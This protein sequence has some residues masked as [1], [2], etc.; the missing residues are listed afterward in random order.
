MSF[1]KVITELEIFISNIDQ[2]SVSLPVDTQLVLSVHHS[3]IFWSLAAA[4]IITGK[5]Q[6]VAFQRIHNALES[7]AKLLGESALRPWYIH[8]LNALDMIEDAQALKDSEI[9]S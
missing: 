3:D 5:A 4:M 2:I 7:F 8:K 9:F 1:E 6:P